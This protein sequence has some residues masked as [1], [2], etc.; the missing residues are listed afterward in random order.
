MCSL[1]MLTIIVNACHLSFEK[2]DV[3]RGEEEQRRGEE[4]QRRGE[5]RKSKGKGEIWAR[6]GPSKIISSR[7]Q[8]RLSAVL[9]TSFC[10]VV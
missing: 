2:R 5:E 7:A 3:R 9:I 6:G 8:A 10:G 1:L 4:E